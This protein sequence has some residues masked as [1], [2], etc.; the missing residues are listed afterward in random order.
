MGGGVYA[1]LVLV[2]WASLGVSTVIFFFARHG[3]RSPLWYLIGLALGPML[4][5]IAAEMERRSDR[6]L[7][8]DV[9]GS[10]RPDPLTTLTVLGA[11]DGS[12]ESDRALREIGR[13]LPRPETHVVLLTV[14]DPDRAGSDQQVAAQDL[15]NERASWLAEFSAPVECVVAVGDPAQ[16]IL[17][18]AAANDVDLLFLGRRGKGPSH[19][20]LGSVA[21][22]VVKR[23]TGAVLLGPP[24]ADGGRR[25]ELGLDARED[26]QAGLA[27]SSKSP[28]SGPR[29]HG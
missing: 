13:M 8:W 14:L 26:A 17:E 23:A 24:V 2:I 7:R 6:L 5:P 22:Q 1:V 4:I 18:S 19:R 16:T 15:L 21:S 25:A 9:D 28:A 27:G 10:S 11:V 29:V 20:L 12:S 3:R